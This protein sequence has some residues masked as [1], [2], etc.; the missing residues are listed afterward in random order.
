VH[1]LVAS[2]EKSAYV[3]AKHGVVGLTKV[4]ALENAEADITCNAVCPGWVETPLVA[5]QIE[6]RAAREGVTVPQA[7][8]A[9]L[10]EKQP[11]GRFAGVD[12]V[13]AAVAFLCGPAGG[14]ITG[15]AL[16]VDGAWT[17]Q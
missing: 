15:I 12:D 10:G 8:A 11:S 17:A 2:K 14:A 16:P 4:V 1:G 13:A 5:R 7:R 3:A 9:L 6:D